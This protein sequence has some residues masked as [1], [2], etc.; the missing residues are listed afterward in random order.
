[1]T[2]TITLRGLVGTTPRHMVTSDGLP[3]T[4]FRLAATT[5]R[6]N[7]SDPE[8]VI[9]DSDWFTVTTFRDLAVNVVKSIEKGQRILVTGKLRIRE[10]E[11]DGTS[12]TNVEVEA[13]SLGHDL[14][15]G[16]AKFKRVIPTRIG[17]L[18]EV[19]P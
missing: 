7:P 9:L 1:M 3:I 4:S 17:Q 11:G 14:A 5:E 19:K 12:G 13:E 2:S 16:E 6:P 8:N 10:W 15:Y 18:V